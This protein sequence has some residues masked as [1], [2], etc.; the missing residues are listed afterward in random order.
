ML[1]SPLQL[2]PTSAIRSLVPCDWC[3]VFFFVAVTRAFGGG[4]RPDW[5]DGTAAESRAAVAA[6]AGGVAVPQEPLL[7]DPGAPD[8]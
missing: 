5:P 2:V 6:G 3:A 8:P 1:S 4:E 7:R